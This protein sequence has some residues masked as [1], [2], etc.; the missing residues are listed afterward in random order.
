MKRAKLSLYGAFILGIFSLG[1]GFRFWELDTIPRIN[2]DEAWI[3]WKANR[4]LAGE[5]L[6]FQ[7]N[8]AILSNPFF[9]M[10]SIVV[11]GLLPPGGTALRI[12]AA[13]SGVLALVANLLLGRWALGS[14]FA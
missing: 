8:S 12:V 3:G 7:S 1:V 14:V 11:H 6:D 2:G 4:F 10:P 5:G 9:L 13:V